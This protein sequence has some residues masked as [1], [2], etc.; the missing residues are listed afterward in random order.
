[1]ICK[2]GCNVAVSGKQDTLAGPHV[3][4]KYHLTVCLKKY[5]CVQPKFTKAKMIKVMEATGTDRQ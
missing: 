1:M 5:R 3:T 2:I 4:V